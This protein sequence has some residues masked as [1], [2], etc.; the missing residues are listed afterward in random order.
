M[1]YVEVFEYN[2]G[3][4]LRI[5]GLDVFS[6]FLFHRIRTHSCLIERFFLRRTALMEKNTDERKFCN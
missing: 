6:S 4:E 3:A 5:S 2:Y 1:K